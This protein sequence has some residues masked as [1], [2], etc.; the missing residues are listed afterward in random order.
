MGIIFLNGCTSAGKTSIARALQARPGRP[1]LHFGIDDGFGLLPV[2]LSGDPD[3]FYFD[4]D[5]RGMV[6]L[7]YGPVGR[8]ALAA[9]RRAAMTLAQGPLDLIV[10]EVVLDAGFADDWV[11]LAAG[12]DVFAV[13]VHC[14]LAELE[15]RELARGDRQPGQARGQFDLVHRWFAYDL[16]VDTSAATPASVAAA[17]DAAWTARSGASRLRRR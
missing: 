12:C 15:R 5:E 16:E 9:Y 8:E 7:N 1:L 14:R 2:R 3:G 13:G 17:I 6:R 4:R 11:T 10:D